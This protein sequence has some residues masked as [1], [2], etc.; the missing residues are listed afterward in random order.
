MP[1]KPEKAG[2]YPGGSPNS[3]EWK[4]LRAEILERDGHRCKFCGAPNY[5]WIARA[6]SDPGTYQLAKGQVFDV[7]G[8]RL[9][10]SDVPAGEFDWTTP[11]IVQVVL[12]IMHL[13]HDETDNDPDNLASG[14]QRCHNI[15]D[16]PHRQ[17]NAAATRRARRAA[18]DLFDPVLQDPGGG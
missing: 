4:A 10:S 13:N 1:I 9:K 6:K 2:R 15:Y 14:C 3:A 17:K 7:K 11:R 16:Q 8:Q 5:Q 18:R 12:T